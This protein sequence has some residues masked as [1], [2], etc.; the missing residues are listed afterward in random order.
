MVRGRGLAGKDRGG[1]RRGGE[2]MA[3][4]LLFAVP[5]I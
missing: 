2:K 5:E 4:L 3:F 1:E